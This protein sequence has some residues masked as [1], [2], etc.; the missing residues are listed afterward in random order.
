MFRYKKSIPVSY[1]RQGY[2]FYK[3]RCYRE[4]SEREQRE[5]RELCR[6]TGGEYWQALLEFVTTDAGAVNV[7]MR[8]HLSQS[9]LERIVRKYYAE[10]PL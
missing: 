3:S 4:L 6:R 1:N 9:T 8:H 2:I 10:F 7:C 5:I